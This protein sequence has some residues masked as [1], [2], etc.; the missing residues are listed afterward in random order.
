MR[1]EETPGAG[2]NFTARGMMYAAA[3]DIW[4]FLNTTMYEITTPS[5]APYRIRKIGF[6]TNLANQICGLADCGGLHFD[7]GT[8]APPLGCYSLGGDLYFTAANNQGVIVYNM[9]KDATKE[10]VLATVLAAMAAALKIAGPKAGAAAVGGKLVPAY[11]VASLAAAAGSTGQRE[12]RGETGA[13]RRGAL[14]IFVQ[15][16]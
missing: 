7:S 2:P 5:G 12:G 1:G 15:G 11:A 3:P 9:Y 14:V 6:Q 10:L 8:W 4:D 16:A 13:G